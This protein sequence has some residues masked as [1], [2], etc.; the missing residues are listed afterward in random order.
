MLYKIEKK[1]CVYLD[2]RMDNVT[3][4][5]YESRNCNIITANITSNW[6][7]NQKKEIQQ[8]HKKIVKTFGN[9]Q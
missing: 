8:K 2:V 6:P 5:V 1:L 4:K 9:Y 3:E 7:M